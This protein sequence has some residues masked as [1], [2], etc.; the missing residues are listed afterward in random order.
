MELMKKNLEDKET[1][2]KDE[3]NRRKL[4]LET[5]RKKEESRKQM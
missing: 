1:H 5:I 2:L 4:I 3:E